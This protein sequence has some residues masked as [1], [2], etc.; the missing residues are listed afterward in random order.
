MD[1]NEFKQIFCE[2][3]QGKINVPDAELRVLWEQSLVKIS[4]QKDQNNGNW[5]RLFQEISKASNS[6]N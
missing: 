3:T 1:F 5:E 2:V 4:T 6:K